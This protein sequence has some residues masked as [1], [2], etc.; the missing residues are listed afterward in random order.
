MHEI[1][2]SG[3]FLGWISYL[4]QM[5]S[6]L[7]ISMTRIFID[8][9][10]SRSIVA[11]VFIRIFIDFSY[12][13]ACVWLQSLDTNP[14]LHSGERCGVFGLARVATSKGGVKV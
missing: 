12:F 4:C 14:Y 2:I 1:S 7:V 9:C 11:D 8:Y 5:S 6:V 3:D 10:C 13:S